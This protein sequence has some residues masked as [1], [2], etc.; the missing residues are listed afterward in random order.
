MS[1]RIIIK[2]SRADLPMLRDRYPFVYLEHGRLEVDDSS[3]KWISADREIFRIPVA[4]VST[5][6]LGPGTSV[7]HGAIKILAET[8]IFII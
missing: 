4:T 5:L 7:T 2:A 6:L 3:I 1:E 8:K